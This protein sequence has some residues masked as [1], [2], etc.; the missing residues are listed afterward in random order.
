M[1]YSN[2]RD[3]RAT[4][5][6]W[7]RKNQPRIEHSLYYSGLFLHLVLYSLKVILSNRCGCL[8]RNVQKNMLLIEVIKSYLSKTSVYWAW[9]M[10][11]GDTLTVWID[12]TWILHHVTSSEQVLLVILANR[13][14]WWRREAGGADKNQF[15][16]LKSAGTGVS[17]RNNKIPI[18]SD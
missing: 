12:W 15:Y 1:L 3:L 17:K 5:K 13:I 14:G 7:K 6:K 16:F 4:R 9:T 11:G 2:R 8:S 10:G 18:T